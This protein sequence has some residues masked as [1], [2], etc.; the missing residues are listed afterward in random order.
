MLSVVIGGGLGALLG[1][2][3][4]CSSGTCPL[5]STWWRGA[6]YGAAM[7]LLFGFSAR[8]DGGRALN[9]STQHVQRLAEGDFD[10]MMTRAETPVL[11]DFYATWCGPCKALAPVVDQLAEAFAGQV[12]FVKVNVDEAPALAQR[13]NIAGV[14]TLL[15]FKNGQLVDRAVGLQPAEEIKA[16]L[17]LLV[18]GP[19]TTHV[20]AAVSHPAPT[21]GKAVN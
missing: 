14:P 5:T 15:F 17:Q 8:N 9:Q 10:V 7:G 2:Y 21:A 11:V 12:K 4:Q 1:Y 19:E 20:A 3:G 6:M 13:F 16:H 18:H